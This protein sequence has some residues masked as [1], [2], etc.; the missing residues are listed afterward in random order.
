MKSQSLI[1]T[2]VC[3]L[4][5][6][7]LYCLML[8]IYCVYSC[9]LYYRF[10][11]V[12]YGC[13]TCIGNSG[14]LPEPV[15]EAIEKVYMYLALFPPPP[16]PP[17]L[18]LSSTLLCSLFLIYLFSLSYSPHRVIWLLPVSCLVIVILKV[19]STLLLVLTI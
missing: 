14:P 4:R 10:N 9:T 5:L 1:I 19:V 8:V 12:G 6:D 15:T 16:P 3:T 18:S 13:M 17:S 11:L 7:T 2:F